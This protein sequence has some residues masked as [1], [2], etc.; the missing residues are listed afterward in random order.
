[1]LTSLDAAQREA[2]AD[3]LAGRIRAAGLTAPAILLLEW[4][5]PLA[6]LGGQLLLG[7]QPLL[8]LAVGDAN[9]REWALF[10]EQG[11][12]IERLVRRLEQGAPPG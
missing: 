8:G 12:N 10:F 2:M 3:R 6:F 4:H 1:M 11:E 9:A 5:R 7:L